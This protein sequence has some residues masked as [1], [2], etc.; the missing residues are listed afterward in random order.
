MTVRRRPFGTVMLL[1]LILA[2]LVGAW[3]YKE[4][5]QPRPHWYQYY[6]PELAYYHSGL[7]ILEGRPVSH[8][9]HPGTPV[10][11]MTA[12]GIALAGKSV[13]HIPIALLLT[14]LMLLL[15]VAVAILL[16]ITTLFQGQP[17]YIAAAGIWSFYLSGQSLRYLDLVAPEGMYFFVTSLLAALIWRSALRGVDISGA[18]L[19]GV[20]FGVC[21]STKFLFVAW[22]PALLLFQFLAVR[23]GGWG[24][25][26]WAVAGVGAGMTAGFLLATHV[27]VD[28]Y[29]GMARWLT[30]LGTRDGRYGSGVPSLPDPAAFIANLASALTSA[31]AWYLWLLGSTV[32]FA[33]SLA[34]TDN[35][36]QARWQGGI[37]LLVFLLLSMA[38]SHLLLA[39]GFSV[40]YLMPMAM[41]GVLAF[42]ALAHQFGGF[43]RGV[44]GWMPLLFVSLLLAKHLVQERREHLQLLTS[45]AHLEEWIA[46]EIEVSPGRNTPV[47]I[48]SFRVP[49][50]SYAERVMAPEWRQQTLD[51]SHPD[52]GHHLPW[53]GETRMPGHHLRWD[54]VVIRREDLATF[55]SDDVREIARNGDYV[56]A[57][58]IRDQGYDPAIHGNGNPQ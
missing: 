7:E 6:D 24:M 4:V 29:D 22:L 19:T 52:E 53:S 41:L 15:G 35:R 49:V 20:A 25:R 32:A 46:S 31:K 30:A 21:L 13:G 38:G 40:R 58:N 44:A 27:V 57:E 28:R 2:P 36:A 43:R 18:L 47:V 37:A 10:Q 42:A 17:W 50:R 16:L 14:R 48:Y 1:L 54:L 45:S 56:I 11:L 8:V 55:G 26:L 3:L 12:A 51:E 33:L 39:R 9:H 34:A 5:A 23:Q